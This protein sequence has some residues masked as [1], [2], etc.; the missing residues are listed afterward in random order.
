MATPARAARAPLVLVVDDEAMLGCLM[1]RALADAGYE[2]LAAGDGEQALEVAATAAR[3]IDALVTDI[4]MPKMSGD[5]LAGIM[6][7]THPDL[8]VL[9]V[10]GYDREGGLALPGPVLMKPFSTDDLVTAVAQLLPH[11]T[12]E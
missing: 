2:V 6:L 8:R 5:A 3:P 11:P 7:E 1:E 9:F 12:N 10:T 4:R